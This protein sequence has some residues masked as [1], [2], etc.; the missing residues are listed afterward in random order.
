MSNPSKE[1]R[2]TW[3]IDYFNAIKK[4]QNPMNGFIQS[5]AILSPHCPASSQKVLIWWTGRN[6]KCSGS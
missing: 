2:R 5:G 4:E 1:L 3:A 6:I